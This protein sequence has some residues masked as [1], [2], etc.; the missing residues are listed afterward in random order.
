MVRGLIVWKLNDARVAGARAQ[1]HLNPQTMYTSL[2]SLGVPGDVSGT[3]PATLSLSIGVPASFGAFTPG[4]S[5]DYTTAL[6]ANVIS[7]AGDATLTVHDASGTAA[8]HLVNGSFVLPQA[9]QAMATSAGGTG[10][11]FAPLGAAP[12]SLLS[13]A[14]PVSNDAVTIGLKQSVGSSDPLRTG[15][16]SKTLTFTLSTTTP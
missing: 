11:A 13:Y 10:G 12:T 8:R 7:T 4:V 9:L 15:R 14:G 16:Y 2:K 1:S 6:A 5:R 3:V